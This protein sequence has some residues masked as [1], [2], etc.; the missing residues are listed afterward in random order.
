MGK[1]E[2]FTDLERVVSTVI[3]MALF[4]QV[5]RFPNVTTLFPSESVSLSFFVAG[6]AA[7]ALIAMLKPRIVEQLLL[8]N[9]FVI[10]SAVAA[11]AFFALQDIALAFGWW[12]VCA[13]MAC[14]LALGAGVGSAVLL[15][16]WYTRLALRGVSD[17]WMLMAQLFGSA[18]LSFFLGLVMYSL[19]PVPEVFTVLVPLL[20]G[21]C[22]QF[23]EG[24]GHASA[25]GPTE[26]V[27]RP[28]VPD[29]V[30]APL[31][32]FGVPPSGTLLVLLVLIGLLG[33]TIL[34]CV[35]QDGLPS[36]T[37]WLKYLLSIAVIAAAFEALYRSH[38]ERKAAF[39]IGLALAIALIG[40][41]TLLGLR[42]GVVVAIGMAVVTSCR[43][44]VEVLVVFL[45]VRD[46][47]DCRV[48]YWNFGALFLGPVVISCVLGSWVVPALFSWLGVTATSGTSVLVAALSA[49]SVMALVI[50][51]GV[52]VVRS[53]DLEPIPDWGEKN[54]AEPRLRRAEEEQGS[55]VG[56]APKGIDGEVPAPL[57]EE[58]A[59]IPDGA[60]G[61]I[62]RERGLTARETQILV[63]AFRGYSLQR[64]AELDVVSLNTVKS[65][66]KNLYRK[67]DVHTRQELIDFVEA[68]L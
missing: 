68:R 8:R 45:L 28:S 21:L 3:G 37:L 57:A 41:M 5:L 58:T 11:S 54:D 32:N 12:D 52:L 47:F 49:V 35:P 24:A 26:G 38:N 29:N 65:H 55:I 67:L 18:V 46:S 20:A 43:T 4:W 25:A 33:D 48:A 56:A 51:L 64:I 14:V 30:L 13:P 44:C 2:K 36:Y 42:A 9:R 59:S 50:V 40:G 15:F 66:W 34:I 62:A 31:S 6:L 1:A 22:Y 19:S 16:A 63:Y 17:D 7:V 39:A 27:S 60:L 10:A 23:G 53:F 61:L